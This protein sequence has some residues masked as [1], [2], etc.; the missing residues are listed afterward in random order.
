[1][2]ELVSEL[3]G[4]ALGITVRG[5]P[6]A[7]DNAQ[8]A[9]LLEQRVA[10]HDDLR[11]LFD[12]DDLSREVVEEVLEGFVGGEDAHGSVRRLAAVGDEYLEQW[13]ER[14]T[15][16]FPEAEVQFYRSTHLAEAWS[17]I[18]GKV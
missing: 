8:L 5:N 15:S 2:Y 16:A 11:V 13:S 10:E 14:L 4:R 7:E 17:W 1:M 6:T 3:D 18:R 9:A 12:L